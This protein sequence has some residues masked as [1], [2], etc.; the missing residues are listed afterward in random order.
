[1]NT[2]SV[3]FIAGLIAVAG[4]GL[5][6]RP[7]SKATK[8]STR[9]VEA[10]DAA[11]LRFEFRNSPTPNKYLIETMGGG[12]AILDYDQDGW[13]DVFFVNGARLKSPQ[14]DSEPPD[15]S[16][17]EF[18]NRLFRNNHDGTFTDV[19]EK[20]GVRGFGYGMGVAVGDYDNDGYPDLF[21]TNFGKCI[22]YHNNGDGTFTDVTDQSGIRT[23]GW[24]MSAG[25]L[26]Y[27]NDGHL[28]LFVTRYLEWDFAAGAK[29]C[30]GNSARGCGTR[31]RNN[32][33]PWPAARPVASAR[34]RFPA[35]RPP[36]RR[37]SSRARGHTKSIAPPARQRAGHTNV[38]NHFRSRFQFIDT[39]MPG[40]V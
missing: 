1:M 38:M 24:N 35:T 17:P 6:T 27:D 21:V 20:A 19:T 28:D 15:K 29:A 25:F 30:G 34:G 39:A 40:F 11:G 36:P 12:V 26:D 3:K 13:P 22:L 7:A 31:A 16:P 2:P 8:I 32:A 37:G 9:F 18:W 33:A 14:P 5:A 23:E 10:Q 4:L